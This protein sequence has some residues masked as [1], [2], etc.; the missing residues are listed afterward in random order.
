MDIELP[1]GKRTTFYRFFEILPAVVSYATL[2]APIVLS[3]INPIY[4]AIFILIYIMSFTVRAIGMSFRTIQGFRA[5]SHTKQLDWSQ[6]LSELDDPEK[7]LAQSHIADNA[8]GGRQHRNHLENLSQST[9]RMTSDTVVNVAMI[10]AYNESYEILEPTLR[11]VAEG[12]YDAK[13]LVVVLAYEERGGEAIDETIQRLKKEFST[14]FRHLMAVKHPDGLPNEVIGKGGNITYAGRAVAAWCDEHKIDPHNVIVT[15]LDADNRPHPQFF[16]YLTYSFIAHPDPKHVSFQP[17]A[18][19]LNNI[20]DAPAAM[21][22]IATGNSFWNIINSFRPNLLRNFSSH[23]QSLA[24]LIE[25]DF[26]SVRTIVEDGHQFWRSYFHFN[27][28]YRVEPLY[29][30]IYQDAVLADTY[31]KTLIVQFKQLRRWAYGASD[32]AYVAERV[33]T[34]KRTVP[35]ID[36]L[37]KF[38]RLFEGHIGWATSGIIILLGAWVPLLVNSTA[39][40]SIVAH[41]LPEIVSNLQRMVSFGLIITI[42]L[43]FKLLPPRPARYKRRRN[44]FMLAQWLL[45]PITSVCYGA[46][47]ALTAQ[48]HLLFG[49]YLEKFDVTDKATV[50]AD[51]LVKKQ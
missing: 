38:F 5:Y 4:G 26:W 50:D 51:T 32:I 20:W 31:K 43:T 6:R 30:P 46:A 34:S 49:K 11:A 13:K 14:V 3:L 48:T 33:F 25:M 35:L 18:L 8:W 2:I 24:A 7:Y 19:F 23:S 15:T 42:F 40:Q 37:E 16:T 28:Y 44:F 39:N 17:L 1:V 21:R 29:L 22:V 10:A 45:M 27:G 36:G 9:D 41:Q 12:T 47:A